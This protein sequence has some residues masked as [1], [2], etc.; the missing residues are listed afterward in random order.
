MRAIS[1]LALGILRRCGDRGMIDRAGVRYRLS[2]VRH[3]EFRLTLLR[4][5]GDPDLSSILDV[6][7]EG[8]VVLHVEWTP[9]AVVRTSYK[10]G[11]WEAKLVRYD[12]MPAL[13]GSAPSIA[14]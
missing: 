13:A 9:E 4:P 6:K 3:N 5:I 2:E 12:R 11:E 10:P 1:R 14:L 8:A 7:F